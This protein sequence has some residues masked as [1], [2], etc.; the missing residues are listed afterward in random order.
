MNLLLHMAYVQ[1]VGIDALTQDFD[2]DDL[3]RKT[4]PVRGAVVRL[5]RKA[6]DRIDLE[7]ATATGC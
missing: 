1:T 2:H 4:H 5:F 6:A 3:G 7:P